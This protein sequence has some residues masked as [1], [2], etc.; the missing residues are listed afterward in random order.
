MPL[1][2]GL[3]GHNWMFPLAFGFFGIETKENWI[4][5]MEQLAKAIGPLPRLAV[6]TDA[7]RDLKQQSSKFS[8]GQNRWSVSDI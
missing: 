6:C 7:S 4:S 8:H 1:A 2:L 3:D 5:F